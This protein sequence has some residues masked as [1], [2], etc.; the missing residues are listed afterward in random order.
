M[1]TAKL[2]LAAQRCVEAEEAL[3]AAQEDLRAEAVSAL[4]QDGDRAGQE[5]EVTR[6]TGWT[7]EQLDSLEAAAAQ[8]VPNGR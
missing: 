6:I 8:D 2:E 7:S 3:K 5:A 1:D 4:R